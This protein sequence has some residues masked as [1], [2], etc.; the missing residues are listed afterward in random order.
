[1]KQLLNIK[2]FLSLVFCVVMFYQFKDTVIFQDKFMVL[3]LFLV[4]PL[5]IYL[6]V[7]YLFYKKG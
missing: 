7:K 5:L 1:M 2:L 6:F 3:T 4:A